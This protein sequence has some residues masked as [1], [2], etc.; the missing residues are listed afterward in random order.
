MKSIAIVAVLSAA[1]VMPAGVLALA[2]EVSIGD[3]IQVGTVA[4][5]AL[6]ALLLFLWRRAERAEQRAE[7]AEDETTCARLRGMEKAIAGL[8]V[9][10]EEGQRRRDEE[11]ASLR[12]EMHK[13]ELRV[14]ASVAEL[15]GAI[16]SQ[17]VR[18]AD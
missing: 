10:I 9:K 16:A 12:G 17:G 3:A 11:I 2:G 18:R 5:S 7:T 13:L 1:G 14:T 15:K 4:V 8:G 6:S